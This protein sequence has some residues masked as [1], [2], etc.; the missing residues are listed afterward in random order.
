MFN[1]ILRLHRY[2]PTGQASEHR[3]RLLRVLQNTVLK[4]LSA[5][6]CAFEALLSHTESKTRVS[7][8]RKK[9]LRSLSAMLISILET[10]ARCIARY[11]HPG[12]QEL[13]LALE[14]EVAVEVS[15]R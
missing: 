7:F 2:T 12:A 10:T 14:Q 1:A 9:R 11:N 4:L 3:T 6:G 8:D 13:S 5:F 15:I